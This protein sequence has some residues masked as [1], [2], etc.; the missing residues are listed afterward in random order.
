MPWRRLRV[1]WRCCGAASRRWTGQGGG[2]GES[3]LSAL[4]R[5]IM[6][7]RARAWPWARCMRRR[8]SE[9]MRRMARRRPPSSPAS[10]RGSSPGGRC[11]GAWP[12]AISM[13]PALP[14]CGLD[15]ARLILA[16]T[17]RPQDVLWAMEEGL[18]SPALAAV[19]GE[20]AAL[21]LPASRRLQ[22]AAEASG[23]T[24]F[25]LRRWRQ[26]A[27]AA[28]ERSPPNAAL[29]RWRVSGAP[30]RC[31]RR[32]AGR[33][34]RALAG[35]ALALPRRR[36]ADVL[37]G[38]GLRCDGSCCSRCRAG[39]SIGGASASSR[40]RLAAQ[41]FRRTARA[42]DLRRQSPAHRRGR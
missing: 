39:R 2:A 41:R 4:P 35:G 27:D 20:V 11:C 24:G 10:W 12:R 18:K 38:G 5:S 30:R 31:R 15:P 13:R 21:S 22:L 42:G 3:C 1:L 16:R 40:C 9:G 6:P 7:C 36:G 29:T 32:R 37:D 25:A 26:G 28:R 33:R 17:R 8:A 34:A 19:V 14:P 23:V